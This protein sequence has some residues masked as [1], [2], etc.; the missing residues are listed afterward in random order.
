[1][2]L[3]HMDITVQKYTFEKIE[4]DI[5]LYHEERK[6][7]LIVNNT[8]ITTAVKEKKDITTE[9][10]SHLLCKQYS[11]GEEHFED[12]CRDIENTIDVFF[13]ASL[14]T[15]RADDSVIKNE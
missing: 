15:W 3:N 7:V 8:A 1:M 14:L 4:N 11:L 13:S 6:T 10:I 9:E 2:K 5:I 12:V